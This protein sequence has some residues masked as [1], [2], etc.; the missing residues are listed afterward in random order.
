[1]TKPLAG[2][3]FIAAGIVYG[4]TAWDRFYDLTLGQ[5]YDHEF[6]R[7]PPEK[8]LQK[9][10][11]SPAGRKGSILAYSAGLIAIGFYLIFY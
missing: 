1:M 7:R 6:L 5:L 2:T 4:L 11:A 3:L 9:I 8:E 10:A